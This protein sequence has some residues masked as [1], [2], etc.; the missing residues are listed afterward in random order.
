MVKYVI[1]EAHTNK[2]LNWIHKMALLPHEEASQLIRQD[3]MPI[4]LIKFIEET[5]IKNYSG[6]YTIPGVTS[7]TAPPSPTETASSA[8]LSIQDDESRLQD[9]VQDQDIIEEEGETDAEE[10][11]AEVTEGPKKKKSRPTV[12][13]FDS[14]MLWLNELSKEIHIPV[15]LLLPLEI[16]AVSVLTNEI[17][18]KLIDIQECEILASNQKFHIA[19]QLIQLRALFTSEGHSTES[20]IKYVK[21]ELKINSR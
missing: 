16:T 20:F 11:S 2:L 13:A 4:K 18:N 6:L 5:Q 14:N 15:T 17:R 21:D 3:F 10:D 1:T 12:S 19:A 7:G 9:I 8:P